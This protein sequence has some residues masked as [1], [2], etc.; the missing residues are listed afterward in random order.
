[1]DAFAIAISKGIGLKKV[2]LKDALIIGIY[3]GGFQALMPVIGYLAATTFS[4]VSFGYLI[5]FAILSVLGGLMIIRSLTEQDPHTEEKGTKLGP[6]HMV[7]LAL[8]GSIDA[9]AV[10]VS[11]AFIDIEIVPAVLIIGAV[12]FM[13]SLLGVKLGHLFGERIGPKAEI[14]G[15]VILVLI[16]IKILLDGLGVSLL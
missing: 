9:L 13:M 8:A 3:F 15:G 11:F 16:G 4:G 12:T 5:A 2:L 14:L 1:M 10:G 7:P 6:A